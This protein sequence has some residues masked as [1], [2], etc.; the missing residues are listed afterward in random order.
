MLDAFKIGG[1]VVIQEEFI[2]KGDSDGV[3]LKVKK[4]DKALL[5]GKGVLNYIDGEAIGVK[6]VLEGIDV[7]EYDYINIAKLVFNRLDDYFNLTEKLSDIGINSGRFTYE[8][9]EV[10]KEIL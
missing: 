2:L 4:G 6:Q 1:E 7:K 5:D 9:K 8:I 10:L 3:E